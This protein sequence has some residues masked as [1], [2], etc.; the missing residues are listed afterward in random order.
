MVIWETF[1]VAE[2]RAFLLRTRVWY[3]RIKTYIAV[4]LWRNSCS[5]H[6]T[7]I[8][9]PNQLDRKTACNRFFCKISSSFYSWKVLCL[10]FPVLLYLSK[11]ILLLHH[12]VGFFPLKSFH[13]FSSDFW[14]TCFTDYP[15]ATSRL[16]K[17]HCFIFSMPT[18]FIVPGNFYH[19][20]EEIVNLSPF[21]CLLLYFF[22]LRLII[23]K[24]RWE[25]CF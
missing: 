18:G 22:P 6:Q 23:G 14:K 7:V 2:C 3:S 21:F 1:K 4:V 17:M 16:T 12:L 5:L 25:I 24:R 11:Y 15:P 13:A 9:A 8:Q 20:C 19:E 10:I